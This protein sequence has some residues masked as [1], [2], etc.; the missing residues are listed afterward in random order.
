MDLSA[1]PA[2]LLDALQL[3]VNCMNV[4]QFLFLKAGAN[5]QLCNAA[6]AMFLFHSD[7][8]VICFLLQTICIFLWSSCLCMYA[9]VPAHSLKLFSSLFVVGFLP[10]LTQVSRI[11]LTS[12]CSC[13][14]QLFVGYVNIL[15]HSDIA[16]VITNDSFCDCGHPTLDFSFN[17]YVCLYRSLVPGPRS[18]STTFQA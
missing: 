11:F 7:S 8:W 4:C 2:L 9:A 3:Q 17:L 15:N 18:F 14:C 6:H 1:A 10:V 12:Y 5:F 13:K 16:D